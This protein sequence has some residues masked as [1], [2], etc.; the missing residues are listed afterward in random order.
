MSE[1]LRK[2]IP[3][4]IQTGE[5]IEFTEEEKKQHDEDFEKILKQY[6]ILK[7]NQSIKDMEHPKQGAFLMP[8]VDELGVIHQKVT[9]KR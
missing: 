4:G 5:K 6:G 7:E 9:T 2:G 1:E 3:K 8:G